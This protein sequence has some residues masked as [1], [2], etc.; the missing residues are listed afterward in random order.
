MAFKLRDDIRPPPL[1]VATS[2]ADKSAVDGGST[3]ARPGE[4][5]NDEEEEE[6]LRAPR[7]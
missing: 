1:R 2:R 3:H 7:P 6:D 5:D 4:D